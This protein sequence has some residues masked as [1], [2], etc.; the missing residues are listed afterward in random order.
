MYSL[1]FGPMQGTGNSELLKARRTFRPFL[2]TTTTRRMV[3]HFT[4]NMQEQDTPAL[5]LESLSELLCVLSRLNN[6]CML[7]FFPFVPRTVFGHD[8]PGP[9][10]SYSL[11]LHNRHHIAELR[12]KQSLLLYVFLRVPLL[13]SG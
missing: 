6:C 3:P 8:L 2:T 1:T 4:R 9:A 7:S 12:Y 10:I 5:L 11:L 13:K